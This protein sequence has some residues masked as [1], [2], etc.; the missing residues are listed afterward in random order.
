MLSYVSL[1]LFINLFSFLFL[2]TLIL[3]VTLSKFFS[4]SVPLFPHLSILN[5]LSTLISRFYPL[6]QAVHAL[7]VTDTESCLSSTIGAQSS[8]NVSSGLPSS[9]SIPFLSPRLSPSLNFNEFALLCAHL[10]SASACSPVERLKSC[11]NET[12]SMAHTQWAKRVVAIYTPSLTA[13]LIAELGTP[14]KE[15]ANSP[16]GL[17]SHVLTQSNIAPFKST[18]KQVWVELDPLTDSSQE[19]PADLE[20]SNREQVALPTSICSSLATFLF[21]LSHTAACSLLSVD[22]VHQLP[23][24]DLFTSTPL[25]LEDGRDDRIEFVDR[26][27]YFAST[28]LYSMAISATVNAYSHLLKKANSS[29]E[30]KLSEEDVALQVV[31]DL[32][33]CE[34][35]GDRC[36]VDSLDDLRECAAGWRA[37]LDPINAEILVPL[38]TAASE[39]FALKNHLLLPGLRKPKEV[40]VS[41]NAVAVSSSS[42][43]AAINSN[44]SA[45]SGLFPVTAASRF[46][47][48][49]L[50]MSTHFQGSSWVE[51]DKERS[52]FTV[53]KAD[54]YSG[55]AP[56]SLLSGLSLSQQQQTH[57]E[58]LGKSLISTWGT[59]LGQT[60]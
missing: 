6:L 57:A 55:F 40:P 1:K 52:S 37:R 31:F 51:R 33:V 8:S 24:A 26:I 7:A 45:I 50:P 9:G 38:L 42:S 53:E 39:Q 41:A 5:P 29:S 58:Q 44:A 23:P 30:K 25:I 59:F 22:T 3:S 13:G 17:V 14:T 48:L 60:Q 12:L 11:F 54:D 49:P 46:S 43:L 21:S 28:A 27:A 47:L 4:I 35:L 36:G 34:G 18:W 15:D 16:V 32:M 10:M 20:S 19:N 56:K 2:V